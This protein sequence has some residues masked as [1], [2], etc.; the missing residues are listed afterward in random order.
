MHLDEAYAKK[1]VFRGRIAHGMLLAAPTSPAVLGED[2]PGPGSIYLSQSLEFEH[3]VRI[4]AEVLVR[5]Q[6]LSIDEP[7][8]ATLSTVCTVDGQ[9]V[10]RGEAVV[11]PP[12]RR[13]TPA[14]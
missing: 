2:L 14:A 4:G 1:T 9:V 12:R 10:A 3:P 6:V 13:R 5:V 7:R 11:I 8:K